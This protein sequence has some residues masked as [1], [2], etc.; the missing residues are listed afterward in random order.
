MR[1]FWIVFGVLTHALFALT[2]CRLVPFLEGEGW[3]TGVFTQTAGRFLPWYLLDAL[4]ALQFSVLHSTFLLPATR[5]RLKH[6]IPAPQY[7][8][9]FC[10]VTCLSLLL[11][12]ETWQ[13]GPFAVWRLHGA[14]RWAMLGAF[15]L[16]WAALLWSLSLM[17]LGYQTGWTPWWAWLR[18]REV[19]RGW[20]EP[21]G[22]YRWLRHPV[23]LSFLGLVWLTPAMT[24][25]RA[26]LTGVWTVYIFVGSCLKD[27]RLVHYVGEPYRQY[28]AR[29]AGYPFFPVG[30]LG[31]VR[32][33]PDTADS[34][35]SAAA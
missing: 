20:R 21:G 18:G 22:P 11:V 6:L 28:Q 24:L 15:V 34:R 5:R 10:A 7:G 19:S 3:S 27:R 9:F 4:L 23:Y 8:C 29:V 33:V 2:V 26:V 13:P 12:L 25:D 14:A 1:T 30:P 32:F 17:G 35:S 31:R 16:S